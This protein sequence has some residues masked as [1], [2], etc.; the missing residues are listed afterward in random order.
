MLN[1]KEI[2]KNKKKSEKFNDSI[3]ALADTPSST[4]STIFKHDTLGFQA[5][6]RRCEFFLKKKLIKN[7]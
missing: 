2:E 1:E 5:F 3:V 7:F 6:L 4:F